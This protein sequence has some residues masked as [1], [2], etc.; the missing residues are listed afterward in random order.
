MK[1]AK[2]S[3]KLDTYLLVLKISIVER[4]IVFI[5]LRHCCQFAAKVAV[6]LILSEEIVDWQIVAN[7]RSAEFILCEAST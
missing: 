2:R 3:N 6:L 5:F 7:P 4:D 1:T